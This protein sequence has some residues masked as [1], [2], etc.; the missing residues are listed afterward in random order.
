MPKI[1]ISL[2]QELLNFLDSYGA[3]RS[4]AVSMIL[5]EQ[6]KQKML[7]ELSQ[8]YEDYREFCREDDRGW[9]PEW[10]KASMSDLR[11]EP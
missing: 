2:S 4:R 6:R 9:R 5:Q 11:K 8:A 7:R 1:S 3:N 10:E